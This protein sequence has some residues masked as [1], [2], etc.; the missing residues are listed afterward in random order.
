[1]RISKACGLL[2]STLAVT[3]ISSP[4]SGDSHGLLHEGLAVLSSFPCPALSY[5]ASWCRY[6]LDY[7]D[8]KICARGEE[9]Y[10]N[11]GSKLIIQYEYLIHAMLGLAASDLALTSSN[12]LDFNSSAL[13]HRVQAVRLLNRAVSTPLKDRY[14]ADARFATLMVLTF[15]S[16]CMPAALTDFLTMRRSCV[17]HGF[18]VDEME[19]YFVSFMRDNHSATMDVRLD[20]A[21]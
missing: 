17:V 15:Q 14:E 3:C 21:D 11:K 12:P 8:S 13:A 1:L 2:T 16:A 18:Q 10:V 5:F 9:L 19:S 4:T 20:T 6:S 7:G